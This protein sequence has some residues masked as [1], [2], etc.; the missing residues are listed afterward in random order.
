MV[1]GCG[2]IAWGVIWGIETCAILAAVDD[3]VVQVWSLATLLIF[4]TQK[5][6]FGALLF[7]ARLELV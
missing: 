5:E 6:A 7:S 4:S 1:D 2:R 3:A